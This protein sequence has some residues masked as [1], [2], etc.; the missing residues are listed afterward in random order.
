[1][2][3]YLIVFAGLALALLVPGVCADNPNNT[4]PTNDFAVSADFL[5]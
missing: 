1:M 4:I 2:C 5:N 3:P